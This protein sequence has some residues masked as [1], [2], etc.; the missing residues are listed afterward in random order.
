MACLKYINKQLKPVDNIL[1]TFKSNLVN[2][3]LK[4]CELTIPFSKNDI[5]LGLSEDNSALMKSTMF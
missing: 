4:V 5:F 3:P 2:N 1:K